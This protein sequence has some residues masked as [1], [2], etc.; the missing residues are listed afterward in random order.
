MSFSSNC[1]PDSIQLEAAER[2]FWTFSFKVHTK[3]S[4]MMLEF[5]SSVASIFEGKV[6]LNQQ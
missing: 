1:N 4:L 5:D 3:F 6:L 2:Y